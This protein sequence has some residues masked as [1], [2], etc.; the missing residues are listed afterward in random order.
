MRVRREHDGLTVNAIAGT[1]VVQLAFDV[2]SSL[3]R[4]L[5]GFAVSRA[6]GGGAGGGEGGG[7]ATWIRN[8]R[9]FA[10]QEGD[11]RYWPTN[12]APVQKFRWG[13][14]TVEPARE[15]RYRVAAAYGRPGAIELGAQLRFTM[16]TENGDTVVDPD[17]QVRHEI[18]FNRSGAA[19]QS[20][21][22]QFGDQTPE[23]AGE[24]AY[25][26]L[27]RG[28][29]ESMLAFIDRAERGDALHLTM[30]EIHY[31]PFLERL[32]AARN[33]GVDLEIMYDAGTGTSA[34]TERN[35]DAIAAAGLKRVSR[36]R[37]GLRGHISHH[38]VMVLVRRGT[39]TA[40]WTGSTNMSE[41]AIYA[42]LNVGHAIDSEP[43]AT[44]YLAL[45]R[46]LW[47]GDPSLSGTREYLL[48][49]YPELTPLPA[50]GTSYVF[51]PRRSD[52]AMEY[53][54]SLM[55]AARHLVVLTTPFGVDKRI[56]DF[57]DHSPPEIIKLGLIG[58]PS[59]RGG[60]VQRI[61]SIDGTRYA[62]P[63][64]IE[65]NTLSRWQIER[66]GQQSHAYI[67]TKFLL[68]DPLGDDP[69]LV[70][71][72]ANF[73]HASCVYNDEDMLVIPRHRGAADIY[74][75][76][77]LRMF[78]HYAFRQFRQEHRAGK[79]A[80]P[81]APDDSWTDPYFEEGSERHRERLLFSGTRV[82]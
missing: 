68:T 54:L 73:S 44:A 66:W 13:D 75:T 14:Y 11:Q 79:R 67:H 21:L 46:A 62:M 70:S 31:P 42:Q 45:H 81:L 40:V 28:L 24:A 38:K 6:N 23:Q 76:E 74:L 32:K 63:A 58:T 1:N 64:R 56:E 71:G 39:P 65:D 57:L 78:E 55:E 36:P 69:M 30:Y 52:E 3:R 41:H 47:D 53:Y 25:A 49:T 77:F 9:T 22:D 17:D 5:L 18:H 7:Q 2:D 37:A 48:G 15:Y 59:S 61:D 27:S 33:R 60:Q 10:G 8:R 50:R 82:S 26:W 12:E 35:E 43:V 20:Y 16:R 4:G 29:L 80:L 72:S 34:P 19:S 51:S